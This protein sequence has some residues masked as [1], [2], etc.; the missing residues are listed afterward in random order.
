MS[1]KILQSF[2]KSE[3]MIHP[4]M[5]GDYLHPEVIVEWHSSKGLIVL[6]YQDLVDLAT[7][8][9]RAY[10]RSIIK[11]SHMIS[12]NGQVA[13]R[14]SHFVKTI[15]NPREEM[16]LAHFSIIWEFKDGK[17]YRGYQMSQVS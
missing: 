2:Y 11:V 10:E 3:A 4:E 6:N 12:E 7:E 15:E 17:M 5:L 13:V 9:S 8:M 14:Y 1:K 16:L